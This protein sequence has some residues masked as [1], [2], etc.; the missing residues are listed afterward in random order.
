V[1]EYQGLVGAR[2][3]SEYTARAVDGWTS[4]RDLHVSFRTHALLFF[5]VH[6]A[7]AFVFAVIPAAVVIGIYRHV[8]VFYVE[9]LAPLVAIPVDAVSSVTH[10]WSL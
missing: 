1:I 6:E 8:L 9:A 4:L 5:V 10:G 2:V 3:R 7:C